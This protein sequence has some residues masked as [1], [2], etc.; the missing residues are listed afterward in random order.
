VQ[1]IMSK[2]RSLTA[3]FGAALQ[4][5]AAL[6]CT[7]T[8]AQMPSDAKSNNAGGWHE[9]FELAV[10]EQKVIDADGVRSFSEGKKGIIDIR[11]TKDNDR[12]V[13]VGVKP[14]DTTVLFI[15]M[16]GSQVHYDVVV[17]DPNAAPPP[18][19]D[20]IQS[21]DNIRL[22]FYFVQLANSYSHAIGVGWPTSITGNTNVNLGLDLLTGQFTNAS[23][24]AVISSGVFP[25]L[26]FLQA[27]G[28]AK[29]VRKAAVITAN[30]TQAT[31]SGGGEFNIAISGGFGGSLKQ[32]PYGSTIG[33]RPRY[34]K[35]SG[36][37][38][39]ELNADVSD[40][41]TDTGTNVPGRTIS[42]LQTVVNLELGQ[43]IM[44]AGLTAA[45]EVVG[46]SGLPGLSEI[47]ILGALFGRHAETSSESQSVIFI[48]PTVMDVVSMQQRAMI[49]E[50]LQSYDDYSGT[51]D[52]RHQLMPERAHLH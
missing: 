49:D 25:R 3:L 32:I 12:F 14:G 51:L 45:N 37:I 9:H 11:L 34:D 2:H 22:D 39:L 42:T 6:T 35:E 10:G 1:A 41:N 17:T 36:R 16:D 33:V 43:S 5:M 26:D 28:W 15:M 7:L 21:R 48:V 50:A 47:P 23:A 52:H 13:I 27:D 19:K 40:L 29:I 4:L 24:S 38:E 18:N 44:L 46:R 20:A 30:G 8:S 31:F